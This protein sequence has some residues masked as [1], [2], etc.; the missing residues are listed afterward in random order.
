MHFFSR[1]I[2]HILYKDII[3][4][5]S[6]FKK[7]VINRSWKYKDIITKLAQKYRVKKLIVFTYHI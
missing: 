7:F 5:Y 3:Y 6:C 2:T 1:V 4:Y